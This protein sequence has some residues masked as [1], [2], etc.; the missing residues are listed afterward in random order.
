[1]KRIII[2]LAIILPLIN[3]CKKDSDEST[4]T[5]GVTKT[6]DLK[7][8]GLQ[9][10]GPAAAYEGWLIVNNKPI[11]TGTFTVN[12]EG[13]LSK[14]Q[15]NVNAAQLQ[16][17]STFMVTIETVPDASADPSTTHLLAGDFSGNSAVINTAHPLALGHDL[18]GLTGYFLLGTP[19]T[20][21]LG[22]E[23]SGVWFINR[24]LEGMTPGLSNLPIV[25][26]WTYEGW[27]VFNQTTYVS[28]GK[29]TSFHSA[30]NS[31]Y[32]SLPSVEIAFPGED[33][34]LN[35]PDGWTFPVDLRNPQPTVM[36]SME[37][38]H[39]NDRSAFFIRPLLANVQ[40]NA[41]AGKSYLLGQSPPIVLP[42]GTVAR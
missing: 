11:S 7:I 21:S 15:F 25:P 24:T 27:V 2:T 23:Y 22:D 40:G 42:E 36:I 5:P 8:S 30:D 33:L 19:T 20:P 31:S 16:A 17:A 32:Y 34:I 10:L 14:E 18:H 26:G 6:M 35:A 3:S 38:E 12:A 28:T 39:D 29:I 9:D 1:M 4:I 37:P 13:N 41:I